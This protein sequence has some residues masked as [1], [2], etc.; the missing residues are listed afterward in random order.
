LKKIL[1]TAFVLVTGI[2]ALLGQDVIYTISGLKNGQTTH[3]DSILFENLENKT[4]LILTGLPERDSY[5]I[6]LTK[7]GLVSVFELSEFNRHS[8]F[9]VIRS[10]PGEVDLQI[11]A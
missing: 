6:N 3:L 11:T 4:R 2:Y 1:L 10:V 8:L 5:E 9:K 7:Q